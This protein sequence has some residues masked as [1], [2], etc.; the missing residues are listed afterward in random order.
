MCA[1]PRLWSAWAD[2]RLNSLFAGH[3]VILLV[4]SCGGWY[5]GSLFLVCFSSIKF[6]ICIV[7]RK[8]LKHE[9]SANF[10]NLFK[11]THKMLIQ[12][13]KHVWSQLLHFCLIRLENLVEIVHITT[14]PY[15]PH[16]R[17]HHHLPH[18]HFHRNHHL[19]P[20]Q[21]CC[22]EYHIYELQA[23]KQMHIAQII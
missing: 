15:H 8:L 18:R 14:F 21:T 7:Q 13:N 5:R 23:G 1:Q 9:V 12:G 22:Q 16:R 2:A 6:C 19:H 3:T 20:T 10:P 17:R 4:L 11:G